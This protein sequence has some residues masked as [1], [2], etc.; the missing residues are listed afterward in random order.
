M[1]NAANINTGN[2]SAPNPSSFGHSFLDYSIVGCGALIL[3]LVILLLDAYEYVT[4]PGASM[5]RGGGLGKTV[6]SD[7]VMSARDQGAAMEAMDASATKEDLDKAKRDVDAAKATLAKVHAEIEEIVSKTEDN[8]KEEKTTKAEKN[9]EN[10]T[11]VIET[12]EEIKKEE[13]KKEEIVE[14]IVEKELGIDK[15]CGTCIWNNYTTCDNRKNWLMSRYGISE[16][17][18]KEGVAEFCIKK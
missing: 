5:L 15:W 8:M 12:P 6:G 14:A 13:A 4:V 1:V 3:L 16:A 18:A 17:V 11:K 7:I 9:G 2:R 10:P